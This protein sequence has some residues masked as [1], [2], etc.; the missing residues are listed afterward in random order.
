M[1]TNL[2]S[3]TQEKLQ[4]DA[5]RASDFLPLCVGDFR[6]LQRYVEVD[7]ATEGIITNPYQTPSVPL[8]TNVLALTSPRYRTTLKT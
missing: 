2:I 6:S 1:N 5:R 3:V 7:P 8:T 4:L